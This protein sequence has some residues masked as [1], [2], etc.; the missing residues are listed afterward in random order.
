MG[1]P[2]MVNRL[3]K[4][5]PQE[6]L[7]A[8]ELNGLRKRQALIQHSQVEINQKSAVIAVL[9]SELQLFMN[10]ILD[11]HGCDAGIDYNINFDTGVIQKGDKPAPPP[12]ALQPTPPPVKNE[13]IK[14]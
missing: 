5:Q 11:E 6:K 14:P 10:G 4:K 9:N 13:I 1:K 8:E 7:T 2:S 12:S 3:L